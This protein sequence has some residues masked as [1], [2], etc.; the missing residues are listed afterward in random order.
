[1]AEPSNIFKK[2]TL[3]INV[4]FTGAAG[5]KAKQQCWCSWQNNFQCA[6]FIY[7]WVHCA[8]TPDSSLNYVQF[9]AIKLSMQHSVSFML[10]QRRVSCLQVNPLNAELNPFCYLLALLGAHHFFHVS[11]IRVKL[12]TLRLLMSCIYGAPTLD[13]SRSH[14]TTQHSR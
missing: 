7:H 3:E 10:P 2:M 6:T 8:S 5:N 9:N 12:L 13:V 11:R 4:G 1:M 14:T